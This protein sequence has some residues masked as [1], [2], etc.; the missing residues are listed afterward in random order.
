MLKTRLYSIVHEPQTRFCLKWK[1]FKLLQKGVTRSHDVR[2]LLTYGGKCEGNMCTSFYVHPH[3][4]WKS[5]SVVRLIPCGLITAHELCVIFWH[6]ESGL[7]LNTAATYTQHGKR[8]CWHTC[9]LHRTRQAH[10][11]TH[12]WPTQNKASACVGTP[13]VYTEKSKRIYW[14]TCGL[15]RKRQAHVLAQLWP[16]QN[17]ASAPVGR[18]AGIE[19]KTSIN[20]RY[21]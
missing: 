3:V 5:T 2:A 18:G 7:S 9:G 6:S 8:T 16:T 15:H 4:Y 21:A 14:H 17:T 19:Q 1:I 20:F 13:V 10:V 12:L 11:L